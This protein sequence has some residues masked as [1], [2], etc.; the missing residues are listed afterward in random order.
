MEISKKKVLAFVVIAIVGTGIGT[1]V[2][3]FQIRSPPA[4]VIDY[5]IPGAPANI[6][7]SQMIK[8]GVIG[9]RGE[10]TGDG[11]WEGAWMAAYE[12]NQAGGIIVNGTPYYI[13]LTYEDT[14]EVNIDFVTT[15]GI[16]AVERL[17]YDKGIQFALGGFKSEAV[18]AYQ[19]IFMDNQIIFLNTG[20]S[21]DI[22]TEK[23]QDWYERYKYF[24]RLLINASSIGAEIFS[25]VTFIG[26][27]L[28]VTRIGI[29]Y[30]DL[31]WTKSLV[32]AL[33]DF[34]PFYGFDPVIGGLDVSFPLEHSLLSAEMGAHLNT[35]AVAGAQLV[36]PI[37]SQ[38]AGITMTTQYAVIQPNFTLV[39]VD[40]E[41]Q[42]SSYWNDTGGACEYETILV[43]TVRTNKTDSTIEFW[44]GFVAM[45][46]HDP[47]YTSIGSY[48]A[49]YMYKDV[50]NSSQSFNTDILISELE[51]FNTSNPFSSVGG[52]IA[53]TKSHDLI[54]GWP[55][56]SG[57]FA[58]WREDLF[59]PGQGILVCIES[60]GLYPNSIAN[61]GPLQLPPWVGPF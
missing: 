56:S 58:Q 36:I 21:S 49:I 13:A 53:F 55:Y 28:N 26:G 31:T 44:D 43:S 52:N 16:V 32:K 57:L 18:I 54:E 35:L 37:I 23:V 51:K 59:N 47:I 17:V 15:E 50:I 48:D 40:V 46:G 6:T 38:K 34:L 24:F 30:E 7:D 29:L 4:P 22:Y 45:W 14:N 33:K 61:G 5:W 42:F 10:I 27:Y 12:V 39:G 41:A 20:T 2:V 19:E 9:D 3:I 1:G 60:G 11:N 25:Y 8:F